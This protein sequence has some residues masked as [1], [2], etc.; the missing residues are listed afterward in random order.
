[1]RGMI[2][3]A[4]AAR[5]DG[6]KVSCLGGFWTV[7]QAGPVVADV[8]FVI[9][10]EDESEMGVEHRVRITLQGLAERDETIVGVDAGFKVDRDSADTR[11][12]VV[13]SR[14]ISI[15]RRELV[16]GSYA[17]VLEVDGHKLDE[18]PFIVTPRIAPEATPA[19]P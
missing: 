18:W 4:D 11:A 17:W 12:P 14:A 9:R 5:N 6:N 16:E 7:T 13:I 1:M 15:G 19:T 2:F 8:A 10:V 3:T